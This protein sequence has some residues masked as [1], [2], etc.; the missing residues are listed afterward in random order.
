M[1]EY[2]PTKNPGNLKDLTRV[3]HTNTQ[4]VLQVGLEPTRLSTLVPK[5]SLAT[6]T[7]LKHLILRT[8]FVHI[9]IRS[10]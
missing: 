3:Q 1:L 6:V 5:T 4:L 7:A 2:T 9:N 8:Y 10:L